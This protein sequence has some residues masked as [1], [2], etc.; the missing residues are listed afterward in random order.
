M[1]AVNP[2]ERAFAAAFAI[3]IAF[4]LPGIYAKLID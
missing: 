2:V 4:D 1:S 3:A